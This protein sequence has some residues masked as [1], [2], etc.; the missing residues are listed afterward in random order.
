MLQ[1]PVQLEDD[2]VAEDHRAVA[3]LRTDRDRGQRPVPAARALERPVGHAAQLAAASLEAPPVADGVEQDRHE[4]RVHRRVDEQPTVGRP[5][6]PPELRQDLPRRLGERS[7]RR[8]RRSNREREQVQL[9]LALGVV[10]GKRHDGGRAS[11]LAHVDRIG[12]LGR[13]DRA[14]L[15]AEPAPAGQAAGE[16]PCQQSRRHRRRPDP[17]ASDRGRA[18]G[19]RQGRRR[20]PGPA[21]RARTTGRSGA[22]A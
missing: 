3:L 1:R 17:R 12:D 10:D 2:P 19:C 8:L 22:R 20:R 16:R 21:P 4:R 13:L 9:A 7:R 14:G 15:A 11:G 5:I 6:G 18:S